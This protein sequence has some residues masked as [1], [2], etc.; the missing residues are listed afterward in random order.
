MTEYVLN[1]QI[2]ESVVQAR[3]L[4]I[5]IQRNLGSHIHCKSLIKKANYTLRSIKSAFK[6]H[7][8]DIYILSYLLHMYALF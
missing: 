7:K 3:D 2:I 4:G 5:I 1:D 8:N 6:G